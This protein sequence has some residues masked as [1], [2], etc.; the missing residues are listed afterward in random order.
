[1][2]KIENNP[3]TDDVI[4]IFKQTVLKDSN[5]PANFVLAKKS[6][7]N[8]NN[9]I[10]MPNENL[11]KNND[12]QIFMFDGE[13]LVYS[14]KIFDQKS[15]DKLEYMPENKHFENTYQKVLA[16][17]NVFYKHVEII[18]VVDGK[19]S[20]YIGKHPF[21]K[22]NNTY[23]PTFEVQEEV[24]R[25]TGSKPYKQELI[26]PYS[27]VNYKSTEQHSY[28]EDLF[29]N[30]SEFIKDQSQ[31]IKISSYQPLDELKKNLD[32]IEMLLI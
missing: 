8:L 4:N 20:R 6:K 16:L 1:M 7:N 11:I 15:N 19:F 12:Y 31:D 23:L 18:H 24:I 14:K 10:Y 30:V 13:R 26:Q 25:I 22:L 29:K 5:K 17:M 2:K 9:I 32:I 21:T 27:A 3:L 28:V